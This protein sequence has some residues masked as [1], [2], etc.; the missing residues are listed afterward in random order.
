MGWAIKRLD[1]TYRCW[2]RNAQNDTLQS[3]ETWEER[4]DAPEITVPPP[5]AA[6]IDA[7]ALGEATQKAVKT[8][9]VWTLRRLLG[10]AP[11]AAEIQTAREEWVTVWKALP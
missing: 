8:T 6:E 3:G 2:N 4:D 1:G 11:T 9:V 5:T 10:R 7:Q